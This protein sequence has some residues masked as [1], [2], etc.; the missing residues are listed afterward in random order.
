MTLPK[1]KIINSRK[2][3]LVQVGDL[4]L[5]GVRMLGFIEGGKHPSIN[6][7]RKTIRRILLIRLA[8]IGDVV[9]T[10]PVTAPVRQAFPEA[11][12]DF[13]TSRTAAPLLEN[14]PCIDKI[15]PFDAP[16]FYGK[17]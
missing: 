3:K 9:M 13:L 17:T 14:D 4:C 16:W 1:Y 12:I 7:L 2:L 6:E 8:Y 5:N 10:Q 15:I 11:S